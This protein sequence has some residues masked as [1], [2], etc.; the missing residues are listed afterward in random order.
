MSSLLPFATSSPN[1]STDRQE[2]APTL[3]TIESPVKHKMD[4]R[5]E[6]EE[7]E[8]EEDEDD[9]DDPQPG[10][11]VTYHNRPHRN[12]GAPC[13]PHRRAEGKALFGGWM[14]ILVALVAVLVA[15]IMGGGCLEERD[16]AA[17]AE[18][19]VRKL[20]RRC[21]DFLVSLWGE[22]STSSVA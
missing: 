3:S 9:E 17:P 7:D 4:F 5:D 16:V 13:K 2:E 8:D 22:A 11:K 6:E 18:A 14:W 12:K 21:H 1:D 19:E 15:T 10:A 20:L